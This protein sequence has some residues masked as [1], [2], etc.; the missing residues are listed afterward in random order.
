MKNKIQKAYT[1]PLCRLVTVE[2]Q[3]IICASPWNPELEDDLL[4]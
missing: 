1:A 4:E 2:E 3:D